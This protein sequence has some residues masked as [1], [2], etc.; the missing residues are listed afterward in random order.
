MD[1]KRIVSFLPSATE[2][3]YEFGVDDK[4]FGVTHECKYPEDAKSKPQ[5]I[6]SVI[7]SDDLSS[8][9]INTVTC[10]L[11]NEG[12]NIFE[13]NEKN[14]IDANPDLIISQE[15]CE[16]CAAYTNQ[17]KPA[18]DILPRK[19]E[20]YSMDPHDLKE[21]IQSVTKL[22]QILNKEKKSI[23]I[24]NSL[25]QRIQFIQNSEKTTIPKVLAIEWIEP[26]FTAGHWIPQMIEFAGGVNLISKSGDHSR[27]MDM[28]DVM[29]SDPDIIILMPCGFDIGRTVSEYSSILHNNSAWN[30]LKAVKNNQIYAVDANSFFSKP[31]IRTIDG[32]EILAK[33]IQPDKFKNLIV[34]ANSFAKIS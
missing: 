1:I 29:R 22:G 13:L 26:F 3:L 23:E 25:E 7:N 11:L 19:P 2:L 4:L 10:T 17:V 32:L 5:V 16:V 24:V 20:L 31:S 14:L 28:N 12:K 34:P 18:L 15:T 9:E 30:S 27:R 33:I 21:I 6:S 8:D